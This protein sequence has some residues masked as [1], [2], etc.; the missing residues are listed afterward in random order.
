MRMPWDVG[1]RQELRDQVESGIIKS[2]RA[3]D[4]GC[5]TG[6]NSIFLA[7]KGFEVTG[8]AFSETAIRKAK[9]KARSAGVKVN[10][11]LNNITTLENMGEKFDFIL[12]IGAFDD[13]NKLD[14]KKYRENIL[15]IS[16]QGTQY[17]IFYHEWS[18]RWFEKLLPTR[19]FMFPGEI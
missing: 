7:G 6:S 4:L 11:V 14:R 10:F 19:I 5:G 1:V 9:L 16:H 3:I 2:G 18:P 15:G 12:D 8:V 17:F 13:L